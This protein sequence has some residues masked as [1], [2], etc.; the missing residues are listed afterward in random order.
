MRR[1]IQFLAVAVGLG[2]LGTVAHSSIMASGGYGSTSAPMT[3]ALAAGLAVGAIAVGLAWR[4]RRR[5]LAMLL[6][7][8]IAAGEAWMLVQTAERILDRREAAQA[9]IK[10]AADT[11][12]KAQARLGTA[13]AALA[14]LPAS[15]PRLEAAIRAKATA[16]AAVLERAADKGC[17][18]NCR[19]LLQAQVDAATSEITAARS[20][21]AQ[22]RMARERE[23]AEAR[24]ALAA[25][26]PT[27]S[28]TP[29]ADRLGVAGWALDLSVAALAS[30]AANGLGAFLLAFAAHSR[31]A[32]APAPA[33]RAVQTASTSKVEIAPITI[34]NEP[35]SDFDVSPIPPKA[36]P[37]DP[38]AEADTFA[39]A[40]FKPSPGARV[41]LVDLRAA[42]RSWCCDAGIEPLPDREIGAALSELFG[43]VGL[44]RDGAGADA[45]I[46]GIDWRRRV[47]ANAA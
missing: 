36:G 5:S 4:D 7:L 39:R 1:L 47:I 17:R 40:T 29:L 11:L 14:A 15:S 27:V 25:A 12:D 46:A 44:Y 6:V 8:A 35:A 43:R 31:H 37:R 13:T 3:I 28:A 20:E 9:P 30:L 42:Y 2:I 34:E 16:D 18:E 21:L 19:A 10:A 26:R 33:P 24:T 45:A 23:V 41:R 38:A 22:Q 32:P